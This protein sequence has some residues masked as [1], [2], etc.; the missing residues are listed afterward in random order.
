MNYYMERQEY[1]SGRRTPFLRNVNCYVT[2]C[3]CFTRHCCSHASHVYIELSD[4]TLTKTLVQ[5]SKRIQ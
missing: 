3:C 2:Q 4:I 1:R 5:Q